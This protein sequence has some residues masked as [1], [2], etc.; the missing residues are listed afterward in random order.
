MFSN[1]FP[2]KLFDKKSGYI[3]Q[4][5]YFMDCSYKGET[6]KARFLYII[7]SIVGYLSLCRASH[8]KRDR[9]LEN[10]QYAYYRLWPIAC[11]ERLDWSL[12]SHVDA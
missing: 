7:W 4:A 1:V 11:T 5:L 6:S 9:N 8:T 2:N 10:G 12:R 3:K